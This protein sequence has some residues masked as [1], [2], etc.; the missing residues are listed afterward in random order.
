MLLAIEYDKKRNIKR[1][2]ASGVSSLLIKMKG[3]TRGLELSAE[4]T[5]KQAF[6]YS[7]INSIWLA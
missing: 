6:S 7:L 1:A 3:K 2:D 5:N 4:T